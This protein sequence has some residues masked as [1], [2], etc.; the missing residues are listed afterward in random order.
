MLGCLL[1][2][3]HHKVVPV[4]RAIDE[5]ATSDWNSFGLKWSA[6]IILNKNPLT[7][8]VY[9]QPF[10]TYSPKRYNKQT[11]KSYFYRFCSG[12]NII[13]GVY[14][15]IYV[16][17]LVLYFIC[18]HSFCLQSWKIYLKLFLTF[19]SQLGVRVLLDR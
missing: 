6:K 10:S 19:L 3:N 11:K 16:D 17:V 15:T 2:P 9:L 5:W 1:G 14:F 7:T 4:V 13:L 8:H 12:K 18:L